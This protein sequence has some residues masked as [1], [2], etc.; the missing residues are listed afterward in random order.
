MASFLSTRGQL[1]GFRDL[2]SLASTGSADVRG[3]ERQ[4]ANLP[5]IDKPKPLLI[6]DFS[7]LSCQYELENELVINE[8]TKIV[9]SGK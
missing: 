5:K 4:L 3:C 2:L 1:D 9:V 7:S 6:R 8:S